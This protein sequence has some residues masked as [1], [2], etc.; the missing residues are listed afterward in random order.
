[1]AKIIEPLNDMKIK[2]AKYTGTKL[3]TLRDGG[4]LEM[5]ISSTGKKKWIF[6]YYTPITKKRTNITIGEY[7]LVSLVQAR[8]KRTEYQ[9]LLAQGVDP[10]TN[11]D[12]QDRAKLTLAENSFQNIAIQWFAV[13]KG[14]VSEKHAFDTWR[15]LEMYVFPF[16]GKKP[17][18]SITA[19]QMIDVLRPIEASGK[20]FVIGKVIQRLNEVMAYAVNTGAIHANPLAGIKAAFKKPEIN[21]TPALAPHELPE[22]LNTVSTSSIRMVTKMLIHWQLHTMVRP[23]EAAGTRWDEFDFDNNVWIIPA[24]R[25][26][27]KKSKRREH[28]VPLTDQML[29]ILETMKPISGRFEYVFPADREPRKHTNKE[30]ANTALKRLGFKDRTTAHGLRSLASTTL[31]DQGFPSD[32]IEAALAH[33]DKNQVRDIYNRTDYL[34]RRRPVMV[35]W[36]NRIEEASHGNLSIT[37]IRNLKAV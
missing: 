35:W 34:E 31:N 9:T 3:D 2:K 28:R 37:G 10:V 24:E 17:I 36:S 27:G 4:G 29:T 33:V 6:K 7:P 15:S 16:V 11:R 23:S 14:T 26:K 12:E 19:P 20:L 13:K 8:K 22:L 21:N 5:R 25:M 18:T 30:T 1:M 32:L